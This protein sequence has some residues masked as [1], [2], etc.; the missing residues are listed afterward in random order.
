MVKLAKGASIFSLL[1]YSNTKQHL[2]PTSWWKILSSD[3]V[4]A[5]III[6]Y[7]LKLQI[8]V[9]QS[10]FF[11]DFKA[12]WLKK[13]FPSISPLKLLAE[14]WRYHTSP[15]IINIITTFLQYR[16]ASFRA[17]S[18]ESIYM[19]VPQGSVLSYLLLNTC[20]AHLLTKIDPKISLAAYGYGSIILLSPKSKLRCI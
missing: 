16:Q 19:E 7:S 6:V 3:T 17:V 1:K 4:I 10:S 14:R 20:T 12:R 15:W 13:A 9:N 5:P 8:L 2:H 18:P 11:F